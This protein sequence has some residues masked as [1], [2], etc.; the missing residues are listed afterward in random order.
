LAVEER[1]VMPLEAPHIPVVLILFLALLPL[2]VAAMVGILRLQQQN[3]ALVAALAAVAAVLMQEARR[4]VVE[5]EILRLFLRH[6]EP[7]VILALLQTLYL[8]AAVVVALL[9]LVQ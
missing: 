1:V 7:M 3:L 4:V 6:K 9:V 8:L 2:L 5:L